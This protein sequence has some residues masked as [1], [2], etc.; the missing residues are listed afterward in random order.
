MAER[1]PTPATSPRAES[2]ETDSFVF[3]YM[4]M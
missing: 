3:M 1:S 2:L 4:Y